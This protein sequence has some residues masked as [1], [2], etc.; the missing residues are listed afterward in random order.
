M[1]PK[2]ICCPIQTDAMEYA[3]DILRGAGYRISSF[4]ESDTGHLLL[5]VPSFPNGT[6]YLEPVLTALPQ[7]VRVYGG[8]LNEPPLI[9]YERIDFL[10]DPYYLA[11]N[12]AITAACT[13]EIMENLLNQDVDGHSALILGWGRIG[14]CLGQQLQSQGAHV[15]IA[16]RKNSDL[17]MID[18]LGYRAMNLNNLRLDSQFIIN[19]IPAMVLPQVPANICAIDL[20]S[21][22]GI[23]GENVTV[24]RG[25]PGKMHPAESGRL[26]AETFL[27]LSEVES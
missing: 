19:T 2:S 8:F 23:G 13:I 11:R 4:P 3:T 1:S 20:A 7:N 17:A 6:E 26:I 10:A 15:T 14:K 5:T 21:K 22:P 24:A 12:A 9:G 18:A 16:A 27:R 25:L